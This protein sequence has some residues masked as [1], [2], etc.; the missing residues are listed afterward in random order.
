MYLSMIND[1]VFH[2]CLQSSTPVKVQ[3][4]KHACACLGVC[5]VSVCC[6]CCHWSLQGHVLLNRGKD[7]D[8]RVRVAHVLHS[9]WVFLKMS[10]WSW[11]NP[12]SLFFSLPA[13][14]WLFNLIHFWHFKL[15]LH[16]FW[17]SL[18]KFTFSFFH[19]SA[20]SYSAI[21]FERAM[22]VLNL[23]IIF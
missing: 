2:N 22:Q 4:V 13:A 6:M 8:G 3:N 19:N 5:A 16:I 12:N 9:S 14:W 15:Y 18:N 21:I 7:R 17:N 1:E 10:F 23:Y 11:N 20:C